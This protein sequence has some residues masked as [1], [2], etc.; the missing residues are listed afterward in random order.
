M[1]L[2]LFDIASHAVVDLSLV[3]HKKYKKYSKK[4][5]YE[6]FKKCFFKYWLKID[7]TIT[8]K[9]ETYKAEMK[10]IKQQ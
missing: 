2:A 5:D 4:D 9:Y 1:Q 3:N 8:E 10:H 6:K 7:K